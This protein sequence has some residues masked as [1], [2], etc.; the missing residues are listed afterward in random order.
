MTQNRY[1]TLTDGTDMGDLLIIFETNAPAEELKELERISNDI[2]TNGEPEDV[3]NWM[4]Y[5]E[6][7]GF[8]CNYIDEHQHIT[9][10]RT[11]SEWLEEEYPH[12]TEHYT[13]NNR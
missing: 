4:E 13:I 7:K 9:A 1:F 2:C 6:R 5:L 10:Y 11:S 3:P 12:I 8:T